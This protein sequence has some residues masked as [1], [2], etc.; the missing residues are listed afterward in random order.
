MYGRKMNQDDIYLLGVEQGLDD[1]TANEYAKFITHR[2]AGMPTHK[3]YLIT[4]AERFKHNTEL[5]MADDKSQGVLI[6]IN[7]DKY[8]KTK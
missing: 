2:F 7:P 6:T 5:I 8:N 4:W 3:D 1:T